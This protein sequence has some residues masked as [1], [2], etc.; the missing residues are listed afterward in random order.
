MSNNLQLSVVKSA[1]IALASGTATG[2]L[3]SLGLLP[4]E[5][6]LITGDTPWKASERNIVSKT[7]H[8]L[9]YSTMDTLGLNRFDVCAEYVSAT[10]AMFVKPSN[11]MVACCWLESDLLSASTIGNPNLDSI[12]RTPIGASQLFSLC[13]QMMN[14]GVAINGCRKQFESRVNMQIDKPKMEQTNAKIKSANLSKIS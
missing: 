6:E 9:M 13:L 14:D 8:T 4:N 7:L 10:I 5:L 11:V 12:N 3:E 1:M 2:P